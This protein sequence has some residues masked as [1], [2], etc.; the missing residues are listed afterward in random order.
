M[1][2]HIIELEWEYWN[3]IDNINRAN[4]FDKFYLARIFWKLDVYEE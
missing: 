1:C 2:A 4:V 3:P